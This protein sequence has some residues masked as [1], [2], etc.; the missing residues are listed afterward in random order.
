[1][2]PICLGHCTRACVAWRMGRVDVAKRPTDVMALADGVQDA[3]EHLHVQA[4]DAMQRSD[5]AMTHSS[6]SRSPPN[7]Q[8]IASRC[9][10]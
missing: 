2:T 6:D 9:A 4:V 5:Q 10:H 1:M 7:T 8:Q 3:R